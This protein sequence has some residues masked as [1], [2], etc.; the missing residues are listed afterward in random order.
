ML[1]F[2]HMKRV[3][4]ILIAVATF[5]AAAPF[6]GNAQDWSKAVS[7]FNQKQYRDSIREFHAVL[8]SSPEY[9]QAW[10]YIGLAHFELKGY[11]DSIDSFQ[12][13]IKAAA[14]REK[15]LA[16][17]HYYI[18]FSH[19][20]LKQYDQAAASLTQ[21]ISISEKLKEKVDV[22]ARAALGRSY[23]FSEKY[24]QAISALTAAS[25]E[26]KTDANNYYNIGFAHYKLRQDDQAIAALN[27]SLA[28]NPKDRDSLVLMGDIH[29][30]RSRQ[31]PASLKQA[32]AVGE[33]LAAVS[34]DE[35]AWSLL[36]QAYLADKQ[37]AK[38]APLLTKYANA[39]SDSG[40]AWFSLGVALSRSDQMK[41][42]IDA[43]ERAVKLAPTNGPALIELGYVYEKE[44]LFDKALATYQRAYDA[45]GK[46]DESLRESI[47]RVKQLMSRP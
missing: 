43:L 14:G 22:K 33:R 42:A 35:A 34:N 19:Y 46:R 6:T 1:E 24:N 12:T 3:I 27:Q 30:S 16:T 18:G 9:W 37:F 15:E 31:N 25:A 11:E 29:L 23:I 47:D 21:Y 32:I 5:A 40:Q 26:M 20:Q 28:I 2:E 13:Y 17:G 41:P 10:Y 36:G 44:K 39:H 45:S 8:R 38:A 4:W 7:L